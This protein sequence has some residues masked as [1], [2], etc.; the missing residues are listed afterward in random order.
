MRG[1][2]LPQSRLRSVS[3]RARS[4]NCR[5]SSRGRRAVLVTFPEARSARA[6]RARSSASLG[7]ALA[8]YR[9]PHRAQSRRQLP[10]ADVRALL[11]RARR[12]CEAIVAVGGGSAIDTAK[13]LMVGT[14]SGRFDELIAL[15]ATG[16]PF[17]P[18]RVKALIAVPTTAGTGS[19]V[20][21]WAT[22]WDRAAGKKHSLHLP[23]DLARSGDRRSGPDADAAA[24][25][26][27]AKRA[28]RAVARA[29]IDL[30]RERQ[31]DLGHLRRGRCAAR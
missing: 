9:G 6:G 19:E 2:S 21:P 3:A 23:R 30:E 16:E 15:L 31:P 20:T 22:I 25:G 4:R 26:H 5:R 27:R 12:D 8:R 18:H 7:A 11:A 17:K 1:A 24:R 14:A 10:R 29:R 28:R 13:A